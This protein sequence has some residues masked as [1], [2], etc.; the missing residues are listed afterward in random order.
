MSCLAGTASASSINALGFSVSLGFSA[1]SVLVSAI[2]EL[3]S[4]ILCKPEADDLVKIYED[5][6]TGYDKLKQPEYAKQA[7]EYAK[8]KRLFD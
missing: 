2:F 5:M 7:R 4:A 3:N 1:L 8:D 6:A